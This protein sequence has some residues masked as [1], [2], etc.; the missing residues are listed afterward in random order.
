[1]ALLSANE[2]ET[3][4]FGLGLA[5]LLNQAFEQQGFETAVSSD[6]LPKHIQLHTENTGNIVFSQKTKSYRGQL[7]FLA[8]E[9]F[10][11]TNKR[12]SAT[13][14]ETTNSGGQ[15][16]RGFYLSEYQHDA[17]VKT[18][19]KDH[20]FDVTDTIIPTLTPHLEEKAALALVWDRRWE[21]YLQRKLGN[22]TFQH[23][24]EVIPPTWIVGQ[25]RYSSLSL[26]GNAQGIGEVASMAKS[27]RTFVLKPSGFSPKSSWSEGVRFLHK[28]SGKQAQTL[29]QEAQISKH[30]WVF[31]T[32]KKGVKLP[33]PF[34][35]ETGELSIMQAKIRI[36]P[37]FSTD[38]EL[39][40]IKATGCEN[41]DYIHG[42]SASINTAVATAE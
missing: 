10:S 29:A 18:L 8:A 28:V 34:T 31:Q 40:A 4:P 36:T 1:M 22:P 3:S 24:R 25:E 42:S 15:I 16:Y 6:R 14:A 2:I 33:V 17:S 26:P 38:G 41:T 11:G 21:R 7:E 30:L 5:H 27:K 9:V 39:L 23:L 12:W 35:N 37:Y 19:L 20:F 13:P 32:F